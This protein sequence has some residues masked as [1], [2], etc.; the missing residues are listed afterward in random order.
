VDVRRT[1]RQVTAAKE[2]SCTLRSIKKS[3]VKGYEFERGPPIGFLSEQRYPGVIKIRMGRKKGHTV[4]RIPESAALTSC[5]TRKSRSPIR[6][7]LGSRQIVLHALK[8]LVSGRLECGS[9]KAR[10]LWNIQRCRSAE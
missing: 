8:G 7:K 6:Y 3:P 9:K 5:S 1:N 2:V 10:R 4:Y